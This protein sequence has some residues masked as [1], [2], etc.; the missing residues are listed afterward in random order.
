MANVYNE[1]SERALRD[2]P[3][4]G[5]QALWILEGDDVELLP[6]LHSAFEPRRRHFGAT[7]RPTCA[8]TP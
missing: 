8:S 7:P 6:L 3:P 4:S 5:E 2:E 1:L